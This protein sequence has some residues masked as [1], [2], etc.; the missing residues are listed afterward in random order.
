[1]PKIGRKYACPN[2]TTEYIATGTSHKCCTPKCQAEWNNKNIPKEQRCRMCKDV[3]AIGLFSFRHDTGKH[4]RSCQACIFKQKRKN[5][6]YVPQI[7]SK[8]NSKDYATMLKHNLRYNYDMTV[9]EYQKLWKKQ[10]GK[11]AI[12]KLTSEETS[13]RCTRLFVDHCHTTQEVRGLLCQQCNMGIGAFKDNGSLLIA[14][15]RYLKQDEELDELLEKHL[16]D[17]A[18]DIMS[19]V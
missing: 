3:L 19:N 7:R 6:P 8:M 17:Q 16:I 1:M 15:M 4:M 10:E 11:C 5:H 9:E 2:C 18:W 13:N 12:C 14:A